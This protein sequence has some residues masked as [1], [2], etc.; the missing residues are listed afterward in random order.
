MRN[1]GPPLAYLSTSS[2]SDPS[3]WLQYKWLQPPPRT[4]DWVFDDFQN[5]NPPADVG[6]PF[7][8]EEWLQ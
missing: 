2:L 5:F 7:H 1:G 8:N 4:P 6:R 3:R